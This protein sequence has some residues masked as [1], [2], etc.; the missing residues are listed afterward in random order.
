MIVEFIEKLVKSRKNIINIFSVLITI[1]IC[2]NNATAYAVE[3]YSIDVTKGYQ[4][5]TEQT[6]TNTGDP[7]YNAQTTSMNIVY[8]FLNGAVQNIVPQAL[9]NYQAVLNNPD[10]PDYAKRGAIGTINESVYTMYDN[11]SGINI[12]NYLASEWIPGYETSNSVYAATDGYSYLQEANIDQLWDRLRLVSYVFFVVILIVAGFMIM[13][14]QKIGGQLAVSVFNVLPNVIISL[15]LV[16]F[17]FAIVGL[18]L[19]VGVMGVNV[20]G[21]I[22]GVTTDQAVAVTHPFSLFEA[23]LKGKFNDNFLSPELLGISGAA[24]II[25]TVVG[26]IMVATATTGGTALL[27]GTLLVLLLALTIAGVVIYASVRVYITILSAYLMIILNTILAPIY[28]TVAAFPGQ[29]GMITDWINKILKA[30]L[31]FPLVYFFLNL[32]GFILTNK[33]SVAFPTG[34]TTGDFSNASTGDSPIG[35]IIKFFMVVVLIFFA[36]DAPKMLD[37]FLPV[38]GGKNTLEAV[39]SMRKGLS[40][41]PIVGSFFA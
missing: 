4:V 12:P 8:G 17:S 10:I 5:E 22:L 23:L 32:G 24:G 38:N 1:F 9:S 41:I 16:T 28:L 21:S 34:L 7:S 31:T 30:V 25:G 27:A 26:V 40:R 20:V 11:Y 35:I 37:D 33:F 14:R 29:N 15:I 36:A 13:F 19:N 6:K 18:L 3:S 2:L 39:G